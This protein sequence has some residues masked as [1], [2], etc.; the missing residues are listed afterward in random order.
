[1][2]D[3]LFWEGCPSH[4]RALADLT[5]LLAEFEIAH[6]QLVVTEVFSEADAQRQR[7][8][9]SPTIRVNGKDIVDPGDTPYGLD[10]RVY[11]RRD[12]KASPL[13]DPDDLRDAIAQLKGT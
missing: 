9:G 6:D 2:I 13:P 1:M 12:G 11:F 5:A 10:C 7:F 4:Q 8:I 3:F